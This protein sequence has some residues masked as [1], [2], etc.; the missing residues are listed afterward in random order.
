MCFY[1]SVDPLCSPPP[2]P[3]SDL[4]GLATPPFPAVDSFLGEVDANGVGGALVMAE[5][6]GDSS[7]VENGSLG[8]CLDG[9]LGTPGRCPVS[10]G[11]GA[12]SFLRSAFNGGRL[13]PPMGGMGGAL[14][15]PI[16]LAIGGRGLVVSNG[17]EAEL[18][19]S[20]VHPF[21]Q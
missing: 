21:L 2:L 15:G 9:M 5:P 20:P 3:A 10:F 8:A 17:G 14:A 12:G 13:D 1:R 19:P 7:V 4:A 6:P 16:V 11:R 18:V